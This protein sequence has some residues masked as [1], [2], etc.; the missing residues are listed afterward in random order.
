MKGIC[1]S[2]MLG[3]P[4]T[5]CFVFLAG[6]TCGK[7]EMQEICPGSPVPKHWAVVDIVT[8]IGQCTPGELDEM[9]KI[10]STLP[11]T[12]GTTL[13]VCPNSPIPEGWTVIKKEECAGCC[14]AAGQMSHR[15]VLKKIA[16]PEEKA[17]ETQ[18]APAT[19]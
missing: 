11:L 14:G 5:V 9:L 17:A 13:K 1:A 18:G 7:A 12:V 16:E 3:I 2:K 6:A 4:L 15:N 10:Q 19:R 8:R